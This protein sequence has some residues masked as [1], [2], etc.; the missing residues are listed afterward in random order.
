MWHGRQ[1][2]CVSKLLDFGVLARTLCTTMACFLH[3]CRD[4]VFFSWRARFREASRFAGLAGLRREVRGPVSV[5]SSCWLSS[6]LRDRKLREAFMRGNGTGRKRSRLCNTR[7]RPALSVTNTEE[8]GGGSERVVAPRYYCL[9]A[10]LE[11]KKSD[12]C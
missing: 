11:E 7:G 9:Y 6:R 4:L 8:E 3:G 10:L 1:S 12:L 5:C 2:N